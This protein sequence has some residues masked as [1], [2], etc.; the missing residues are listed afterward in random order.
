MA[1]DSFRAY[2]DRLADGGDLAEFE[3]SV[4]WNLEASAITMLVTK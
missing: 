3:A 2:L 4:S 1:V